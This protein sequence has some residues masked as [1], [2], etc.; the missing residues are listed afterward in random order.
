M[1]KEY[2]QY[3][4][5]TYMIFIGG[6]EGPFKYITEDNFSEDFWYKNGYNII[7]E[8]GLVGSIKDIKNINNVNQSS[9]TKSIL[10]YMPREF[11]S[12]ILFLDKPEIAKEVLIIAKKSEVISED[13]PLQGV[14]L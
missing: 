3:E 6:T 1:I 13:K 2:E 12:A 4:E 7:K 14:F 10:E 9:L 8:I 5:V 11:A